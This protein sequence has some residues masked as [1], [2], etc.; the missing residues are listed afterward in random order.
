MITKAQA[1]TARLSQSAATPKMN[2]P[3][4][5]LFLGLNKDG[6]KEQGSATD[7][8]AAAAPAERIEFEEPAYEGY[9]GSKL[10]VVPSSHQLAVVP[11]CSFIPAKVIF[12]SVMNDLPVAVGQHRNGCGNLLMLLVRGEGSSL[13]SQLYEVR[14]SGERVANNVCHKKNDRTLGKAI[15]KCH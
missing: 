3:V 7:C 12:H 4:F 6:S 5:Q 2:S 8:R 10:V 11:V 13:K 15:R 9:H 1:I 14:R